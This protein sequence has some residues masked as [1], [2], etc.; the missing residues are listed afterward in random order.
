MVLSTIILFVFLQKGR[1]EERAL[2]LAPAVF[3]I[4]KIGTERLGWIDIKSKNKALFMKPAWLECSSGNFY[5]LTH[6]SLACTFNENI[7]EQNPKTI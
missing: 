2:A 5:S 6:F 4:T 7:M 1:K 3:R